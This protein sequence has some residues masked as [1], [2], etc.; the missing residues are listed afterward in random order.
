MPTWRVS[1]KKRDES[2][3]EIVREGKRE[4]V[5]IYVCLTYG[6]KKVLV[7]SELVQTDICINVLVKS[8]G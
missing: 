5:C 2:K 4:R 3:I 6:T 1:T 7:L 8:L